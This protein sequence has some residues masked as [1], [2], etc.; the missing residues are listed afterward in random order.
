MAR[1]P[2]FVNGAYRA[3]SPTADDEQTINWYPE[4]YKEEAP[5]AVTEMAL[6]PT[7]GV[8]THMNV[9][10]GLGGRAAFSMNGRTFFVIGSKL[11][12]M[13]TGSYLIRGDVGNNGRPA[14]MVS[15][16]IESGQLVIC[17]AGSVFCYDLDTNVLDTVLTPLDA[18]LSP[19]EAYYSH[20]GISYGFFQAF[21]QNH[22]LFRIS[23][24]SSGAVGAGPTG[25]DNLD[26]A[27]RSL[28]GVGAD[29]WVA[30]LTTSYGETWFFG[31]LS[32]EVWYNN[33]S[34]DF[35][36]APDQSGQLPYGI[37]APFSC[38][39]AGDRVVWLATTKDGDLS[40]ASAQGFTPKRISDF[41]L[42]AEFDSYA[43][44]DDAE[45]ETYRQRGHTFYKLTFPTEKKTWLFDFQTGLWHRRGT[46]MSEFNRYDEWRP[47]WYAFVNRQHLWVERE[48]GHILE[49]SP[50]FYSDADN[51][52]LRRVRVSPTIRNGGQRVTH[53]RLE[54]LIEAGIQ[55][56]DNSVPNPV[57]ALR[58][59]DDGGKTWGNEL[60]QPMGNLG[61]YRQ[62]LVWEKLGQAEART[63]ELSCSERMPVRVIDAYIEV[64]E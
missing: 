36:Y 45:G 17:S 42:E 23:Q 30:M 51:R 11:V 38:C 49:V 52:E 14:Q 16:G 33:G 1:F 18:L 61:Q 62:R 59:S 34:G 13:L 39:E 21:D 55:P 4:R 25:W 37:A 26:F 54:V 47:T 44:V 3:L 57:M 10:E 53:K 63:Y 19:G 15:S 40:V 20:V 8:A 35:P 46:W 56:K 5:G 24:H 32:S 2:L 43:R 27:A 60:T 50:E 9:I 58:F 41:A 31:E 12:E 6:Y 22:S 29:P 28:T 7:P 64:V 48:S